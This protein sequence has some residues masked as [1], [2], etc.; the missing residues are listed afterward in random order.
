MSHCDQVQT[1]L[2]W[3]Q[4]V[5]ADQPL[6]GYFEKIWNTS[7]VPFWIGNREKMRKN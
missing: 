4:Q 6:L 1:T 5:Q 3:L 2:P 7:D